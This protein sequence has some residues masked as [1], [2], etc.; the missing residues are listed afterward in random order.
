MVWLGF[1][2]VIWESFGGL[3]L[4]WGVLEWQIKLRNLK[5]C[6]DWL[7][8]QDYVMDGSIPLLEFTNGRGYKN[9]KQKKFCN[10]CFS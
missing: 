6:T 9:T 1:R 8:S 3:L 2:T 5:A 4:F 7:I 10:K